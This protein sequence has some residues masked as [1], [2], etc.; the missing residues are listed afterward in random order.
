[1][2]CPPSKWQ[3]AAPILLSGALAVGLACKGPKADQNSN[4]PEAEAQPADAPAQP[5][6]K[7][8][9][10][11][12]PMDALAGLIAMKLEAQAPCAQ[13]MESLRPVLDSIAAYREKLAG[14]VDEAEAERLLKEL[15][16]D[17]RERLPM[18]ELREESD[19]LRRS[20]AELSASLGDLAESLEH[21]GEAIGAHD[22]QASA[23]TMR[24]IHNGV[25]NTLS[26]V[27]GLILQCATTP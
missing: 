20:S 26:S 15:S 17:L 18:I 9:P 6:Q 8:D 25:A 5:A 10:N 11:T 24:R 21:A 1:M 7:A 12:L 16:A 23:V 3:L 27:D 19:E 13:T 14:Q 22:K 4:R 2:S